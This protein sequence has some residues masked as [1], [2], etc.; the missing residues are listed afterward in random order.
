MKIKDLVNRVNYLNKITQN[1]VDKYL[2][3][4]INNKLVSNKGHYYI[5]QYNGNFGIEQIVNTSGG[6]TDIG[7]RG[8]KQEIYNY[9]NAFIN[10]YETAYNLYITK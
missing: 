9:L 3:Y 7:S 4:K 2:P 5:S 10:G 6:C 8:S 1:R